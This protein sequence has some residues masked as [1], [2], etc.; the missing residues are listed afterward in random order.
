MS[1][2][3][4]DLTSLT[5]RKRNAGRTIIVSGFEFSRR[6]LLVTSVAL[7]VALFPALIANLF[8]GPLA[9]IIT[10]AVFVAGAFILFEGRTRSGL[11]VRLYRSILDKKKASTDTFYI[12]FRPVGETLGRANI[13]ASSEPVYY[14]N[15]DVPVLT[16]IYTAAGRGRAKSAGSTV[17]SI[18]GG[19]P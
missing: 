15:T 17:V 18:L 4:Y 5:G 12:C 16:P 7:G 6:A 9:M 10:A 1:A 11:Q 3:L 8:F 2:Y 14:K 19:T 13:I